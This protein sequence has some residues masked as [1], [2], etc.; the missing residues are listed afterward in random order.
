MTRRIQKRYE[1]GIKKSNE[2]F[3][4]IH[5]CVTRVGSYYC[6]NHQVGN[7][8]TI[9]YLMKMIHTNRNLSIVDTKSKL[10]LFSKKI[11]EIGTKT[12]SNLSVKFG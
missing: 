6:M 8:V 9:N 3:T 7:T 4:V 1:S 2:T 11:N 10:N 5:N 12:P